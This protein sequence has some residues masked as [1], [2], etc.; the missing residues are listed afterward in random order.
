LPSARG[1][2]GDGRGRDRRRVLRRGGHGTG[3]VDDAAADQVGVLVGLGVGP[4]EYF[5][6]RGKTWYHSLLRPVCGLPSFADIFL[7][8][9]NMTRSKTVDLIFRHPFT[10]KGLDGPAPPGTYRVDIEEEQIDGLSFV[11]YRRLATFIRL[12]MAGH[13]PG[14]TQSFLVDPKDLADAQDRDLAAGAPIG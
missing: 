9:A 1:L 11:A 3:R 12:P 2:D 7:G 4:S 6:G 10:L 5:C 14:S 13:G 8:K